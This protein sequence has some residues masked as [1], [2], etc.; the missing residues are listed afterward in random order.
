MGSELLA[1]LVLVVVHLVAMAVLWVML[2]GDESDRRGWWPS[3]NDG[4]DGGS[5]PGDDRPRG[6]GPPL[7]EADPA[8]MRLRGPGRLADARRRSRRRTLE[9]PSQPACVPDGAERVPN[10]SV[11]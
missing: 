9:P 4:G 6:G 5:P 8:R 10:P 7:G 2:A 1:V 3:D 11:S